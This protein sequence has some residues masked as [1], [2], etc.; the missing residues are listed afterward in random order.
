M[1]YVLSAFPVK[2]VDKGEI[3]VVLFVDLEAQ[4]SAKNIMKKWH[5]TSI[6]WQAYNSC[7]IVQ[8]GA[9]HAEW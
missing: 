3:G 9:Y 2:D 6:Y 4:V 7:Y 8:S 5:L 1:P